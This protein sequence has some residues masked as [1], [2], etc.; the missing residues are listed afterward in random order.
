[1]LPVL[2]SLSRFLLEFCLGGASVGSIS[3]ALKGQTTETGF[4]RGVGVGAVTGAFT[5]VQLMEIILNGEPFSKVIL[6]C[7]LCCESV[8]NAN[9]VA[10][11]LF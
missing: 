10:G 1:M 4:L 5:G 6:M 7:L 3:G 8:T 2:F 9:A 11:A